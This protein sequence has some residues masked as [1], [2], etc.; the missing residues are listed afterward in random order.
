TNVRWGKS[1]LESLGFDDVVAHENIDQWESSGQIVGP[2]IRDAFN[3]RTNVMIGRA[4]NYYWRQ[5]ISGM[6][7]T[8]VYP[9]DLNIAGHHEWTCW[10]MLRMP[11]YQD[12][13][14]GPVAASTGWGG[15]QTLPYS[16]IWLESVNGFLQHDMTFGWA[17]IKGVLS[18]ETY[19]PG[20][21]TYWTQC[22]TDV[23]WYGD[24]GIQYWRGVP[25]EVDLEFKSTIAPTDKLISIYVLDAVEETDLEGAQVTIYVQGDM[26]DVD[27][28]DYADYGDMFMITKKTDA[29]GRAVFVIPEDVEFDEGTMYLTIT[30][31]DILP[32]LNEIEI[33]QPD[34]GVE[35]SGWSLDQEAGNN[36]DNVN[37]GEIFFLDMVARNL[38]ENEDINNVTATVTS[39]SQYL[40]VMNENT[41]DFGTIEGGDEVESQEGVRFMVAMN[42]PDGASRPSTKPSLKIVFIDG[43]EHKVGETAIQLDPV[44]PDFVVMNIIDGNIIADSL[45]YVNPEIENIGRMPA[46]RVTATLVSLGM[47]VSVVESEA[48]YPA[49]DPDETAQLDGNGFRVAGNRLVV[50]GS[51]YE[52][53]MVFE[54]ENGFADSAFFMLQVMEER[55][56][57][58]QGPDGYGYICFDDTDTD[59]DIAPDYD[60]IEISAAEQDLDFEGDEL[61]FDGSSPQNI[62]ETLVIDLPFETQFYGS[63]YDQITVAT[64]GFISMGDQ[65]YVTNYQNWP[66]DRAIGGGVGMMAPFWDDLRFGEDGGVYTY[67]DDQESQFI[68]EWYKMRQRSGSQSD[69]TFQII[70]YDRDIWITE[71]GDQNII[72]QYKEINNVQGRSGWANASPFAS[73]GISSPEGTTGINY[74]FNNRY[75]VTSAELENR[76]ALLFATSPRYRAG[77]LFGNVTA[78]GDNSPIEG[79]IV[80]TLHGFTALTDADGDWRINDALADIEFSITCIKP[81]FNDS[82]EY[83]LLV[84]EDSTLEINFSLLHPEFTPSTLAISF[85]LDPELTSILPF[86]IENTGNGPLDWTMAR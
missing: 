45:D 42:C 5:N 73:V 34:E 59:W 46:S 14:M 23:V 10:N 74:T 62:G 25:M 37:P 29:A 24:P 65:E 61:D 38:N 20:Q 50:P 1:V 31:R 69:L 55:E 6:Q 40:E 17:H 13:L 51:S 41:A 66:M 86:S 76:R 8:G 72:F 15:Q 36:D 48:R 12:D 58:P 71:T 11:A 54:T 83:E 77:A 35:L 75:P 79:A 81:G 4:E 33:V 80:S 63:I 84:E 52:V 53:A 7:E 22:R 82:T 19:I 18:P 16:I 26:P 43:D 57:A 39:L 70:I 49:L 47:G 2:E 67:Y 78:V 56:N 30:G 64:N 68:I 9:I 32:N 60:W 3:A 44:A 85:M 27:S 21:N 28:D